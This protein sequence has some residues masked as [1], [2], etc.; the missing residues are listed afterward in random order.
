MLENYLLVLPERSP[1][2][3]QGMK[4]QGRDFFRVVENLPDQQWVLRPD[5][6]VPVVRHQNIATEQ[7]SRPSSRSLKHAED[8]RVFAITETSDPRAKIHVDKEDAIREAQPVNLGHVRSLA[9]GM[10]ASKS[11]RSADH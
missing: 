1:G 11:P 10:N 2:A 7:E 5:E 6:T 9:L 4:P 3:S 8:Q